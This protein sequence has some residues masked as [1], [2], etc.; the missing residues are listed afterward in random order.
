MAKADSLG[1]RI[2]ENY[3][4]RYDI[5]LPRRSY[6]YG[7]LDGQAFHTFT[8]GLRKP[9]DYEL[10]D[11]LIKAT[12]YLCSYISGCKFGFVQSDEISILL[13]DFEEIETDAFFDY[14]LQKLCSIAASHFTVKFNQLRWKRGY[15]NE[16]A[17]FDA[18]F[19]AISDP[20]EVVNTFLWRQRD[21]ERNSLSMLAQ[22]NFPHKMLEGKKKQDL[23]DLLHTIGINWNNL[24]G[25]CKRGALIEK[26]IVPY[27]DTTRSIW[28]GDAAPNL[29]QYL[30]T[31]LPQYEPLR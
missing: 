27:G 4:S 20:W 21:I 3:E 11:D 13:T 10:I 5:R 22:A 23:H 8:Q 17:T 24:P 1:T 15:T 12:E 25:I 7:R 31:I 26:K 28:I 30:P 29:R 6:I 9:F 2:K 19:M 18:R 16:K 14:K